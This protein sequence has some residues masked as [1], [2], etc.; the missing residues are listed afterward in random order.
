[1]KKQKV[2]RPKKKPAKIKPI[3]HLDFY[4][5]KLEAMRDDLLKTVQKKR[6]E[7]LPESEV[8]DEADLAVR[9]INRDLTFGLTDNEQHLLAEVEAALRRIEKGTFGYCENCFDRIKAMRL[10]YMFYARYCIKCQSQ[11]EG[12]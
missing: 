7:A 9:S 2:K 8:G 1:M 4:R 6:E 3:G 10:K 12:K 11:S 5:K